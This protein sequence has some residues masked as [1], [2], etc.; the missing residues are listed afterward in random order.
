MFSLVYFLSLLVRGTDCSDF[1][2]G[3]ARLEK[4]VAVES[5]VVRREC[6]GQIDSNGAD[7]VSGVS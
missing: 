3:V 7:Y 6:V 1:S 5:R 4:G 2:F